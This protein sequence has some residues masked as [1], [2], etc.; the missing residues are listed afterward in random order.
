MTRD[1]LLA[2]VNVRIPEAA[3]AEIDLYVEERSREARIVLS[4]AHAIRELLVE[5]TTE[6]RKLRRQ[7]AAARAARL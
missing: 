3:L 4:R 1:K 2:Q 7:P 6:R 5:W